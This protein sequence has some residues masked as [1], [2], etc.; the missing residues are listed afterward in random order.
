MLHREPVEA[1]FARAYTTLVGELRRLELRPVCLVCAHRRGDQVTTEIEHPAGEE[2]QWDWPE[3]S[4]TDPPWGE[5]GRCA[6]RC[7]VAFGALPWRVL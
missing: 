4:A 5:A 7:A 3:L 1:G 2:I 6:R